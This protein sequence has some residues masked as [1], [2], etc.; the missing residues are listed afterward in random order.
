MIAG[1][2]T[3]L[4]GEPSRA[5]SAMS[6]SM[7]DAEFARW[8]ELLEEKT[9][10]VV[11]PER[12]QFLETNLR[13]RMQELGLNSYA[14]YFARE[15]VGPKGAREW[16]VLVDRLTVHETR[17]FRHRPSLELVADDVLPASVASRPPGCAFHAW[18]VACSTGEE[19]YSLA[20]VIDR[21]NR[22]LETP[23]H[24]GITGSDVSQP[25]LAV[26]RRAIYSMPAQQ[27]IPLGYQV[28]YCD[29]VDA[30]RFAIHESRKRRVGFAVMNL[31]DVKRQPMSQLDLIYCQ[32]VLIYFPRVRRYEV[33]NNLVRCLRPGGVLILGP[34]E[35]TGWSHPEMTR[36]PGQRTL[37]YRRFA[38]GVEQ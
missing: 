28:E 22:R 11:P 27:D 24:F 37:A 26:A 38:E 13:M 23:L 15:L 6:G 18:S 21:F 30:R 36:I 7:T 9:G 1:G 29:F 19:A 20:M 14:A 33:L 34:G 17:F 12:R 31:L 2:Q 3:A 32:N 25:A 5:G 10:V 8:V 35:M 16:A 4:A